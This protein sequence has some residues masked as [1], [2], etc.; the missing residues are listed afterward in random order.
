LRYFFKKLLTVAWLLYKGTNVVR[1]GT[2]RE[3]VLKLEV[4]L[5]DDR[6]INTT[7]LNARTRKNKAGYNLTNLMVGSEGTLGLISKVSLKLYP[8]LEVVCMK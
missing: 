3:N 7:G 1:N 5:P 4:V 8:I 6:I 2:I